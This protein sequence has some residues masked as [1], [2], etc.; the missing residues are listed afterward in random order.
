MVIQE[1]LNPVDRAYATLVDMRVEEQTAPSRTH[2]TE[3]DVV[4]VSTK[5]GMFELEDNRKIELNA[6][7]KYPFNY[8]WYTWTIDVSEKSGA[9]RSQLFQLLW[10]I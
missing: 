5:F 1:K 7:F 9:G 10:G 6:D 3:T 8:R 2:L 4:L